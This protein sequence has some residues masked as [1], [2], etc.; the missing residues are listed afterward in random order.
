MPKCSRAA[1]LAVLEDPKFASGIASASHHPEPHRRPGGLALHT[2]E[3]AKY[4]LEAAGNDDVLRAR[5]FIAAVFHDVAKALEY[6][7]T[8]DGTTKS[9][10]ART[11]GH[12]VGGWYVWQRTAESLG[13]RVEDVDEI[14]HALLAHHGRREWGSPVTPQT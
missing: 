11:V 14:G 7:E 8:P 10:F 6:E 4:A 5:V 13:V 12:I 3:V 1:Y 2:L 9:T